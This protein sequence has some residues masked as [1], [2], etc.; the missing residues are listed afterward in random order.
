M[1]S[2]AQ[3]LRENPTFKVLVNAVISR[4]GIDSVD[5]INRHGISGGF[6]G[7]IYYSDT[8]AFA[9]RYRKMIVRMLE[10]MADDLGEDVVAMVNGFGVFRPHG[11]DADDR[12]ELYKYLGGGRNEQSAVTN[13]MA[14]FAAEQVCRMFED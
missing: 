4:V 9:M 10:E 14:W 13:M 7:F 1:K 2:K 5:D 3:V 11:M 12:K 8:H 6:G